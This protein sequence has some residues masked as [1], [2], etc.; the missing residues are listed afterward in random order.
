MARPHA[1]M[2]RNALGERVGLAHMLP[3]PRKRLG[4]VWS[5]STRSPCRAT[6]LAS[7]CRPPTSPHSPPPARGVCGAPPH[8]SLS[9][10]RPWRRR[11]AR[12]LPPRALPRRSPDP[13]TYSAS[14]AL[15]VLTLLAGATPAMAMDMSALPAAYWLAPIGAV[16][17]LLMAFVFYKGF[18]AT[19]E[20]DENMVRIAQ[21]V[22]DGAYAYLGRQAK[23]VY[24]EIGRAHV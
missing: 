23:V 24:I 11:R 14:T 16:L 10:P 18:M 19:S 8:V 15:A 1:P 13:H 4:S 6:R 5:S 9:L 12:S 21:A 2:P 20:G 7:V 17:A 3:V 22:R